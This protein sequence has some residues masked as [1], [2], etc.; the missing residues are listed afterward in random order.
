MRLG[1]GGLLASLVILLLLTPVANGQEAPFGSI[2]S[3]EAPGAWFGAVTTF[4][5][6]MASWERTSDC[7]TG[8]FSPDVQGSLVYWANPSVDGCARI[9]RE[10]VIP[11]GATPLQ[12]PNGPTGAFVNVQMTRETRTEGRD[13]AHPAYYAKVTFEDAQGGSEVYEFGASSASPGSSGSGGFTYRASEPR[14]QVTI[15]AT[16]RAVV[17]T[18]PLSSGSEAGDTQIFALDF[19]EVAFT[20]TAL[21]ST[22]ETADASE[23]AAL[24]FEGYDAYHV[25]TVPTPAWMDSFLTDDEYEI[26]AA[27][28]LIQHP[29]DWTFVTRSLDPR[30]EG[31]VTTD[32]SPNVTLSAFGLRDTWGD[33]DLRLAWGAPGAAAVSETRIPG[34]IHGT[35]WATLILVPIG[36]GGMMLWWTRGRSVYLDGRER[37]W[38]GGVSLA[39]ASGYAALGF[40][41]VLADTRT[42]P[43]STG[44]LVAFGLLA[45]A[46]VVAVWQTAATRRD[47]E[48]LHRARLATRTEEMETALAGASHDLKTPLLAIDWLTQD[49][50]QEIGSAD[51]HEVEATVDRIR[52]SLTGMNTLVH[53]LL[54][55]GA[56][57]EGLHR[58]TC[59]LQALVAK[60]VDE[61]RTLQERHAAQVSVDVL[62][63]AIRGDPA[64]LRQV[65]RNLLSNAIKY[66]SQTPQVR[67]TSERRDDAVV[68]HVDD[69]GPGVPPEHRARIFRLFERNPDDPRDVEGHGV[70]LALVR[71]IIDAHG[72]SLTIGTAPGLGGAR[73]TVRLPRDR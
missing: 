47:D 15:E 42:W 71:R 58:E 7:E 45:A 29:A 50:K 19:E 60:A 17:D 37:A 65:W 46:S 48:I 6:G 64:R 36:V 66:G 2:P 57:R 28:F 3:R 20:T 52:S 51:P 62:P 63:V 31:R 61:T 32:R 34:M 25:M 27:E 11:F 44:G 67:I 21:I 30:L 13:V 14:V 72:G 23:G 4:T 16:T 10:F 22:V 53:E 73:F 26:E 40:S 1:V 69:D 24:G 43:W 55:M 18:G 12:L 59:D 39:T 38:W 35:I 54:D 56:V 8:S 5:F 41:D 49:L 9:T 68:V 33:G 70:G